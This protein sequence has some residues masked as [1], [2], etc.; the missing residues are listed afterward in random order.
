[1]KLASFSYFRMD[2]AGVVLIPQAWRCSTFSVLGSG[3]HSSR[4]CT[5]W[6]RDCMYLV[7]IWVLN[8]V[9]VVLP[10]LKLF[11]VRTSTCIILLLSA[12]L[13]RLEPVC[14]QYQNGSGNNLAALNHLCCPVDHNRNL[15]QT[16][17][18]H[19]LVSA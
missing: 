16:F 18:L 3:S 11:H 5:H 13:L 1:M 7:R 10:L 9:H 17:E 15:P 14:R 6:P 12:F 8:Y 2:P 4:G 19:T